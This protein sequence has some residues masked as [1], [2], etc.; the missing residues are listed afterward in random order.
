M[1]K[2]T[3][4][5]SQFEIDIQK[6][7]EGLRKVYS[8]ALEGK[9]LFYGGYPVWRRRF[10]PQWRIPQEL[11]FNPAREEVKSPEL[12]AKF[13][14]T[15]VQF[16]RQA[17]SAYLE[18]KLHQAWNSSEYRWF[19]SG[20]AVAEAK[21][22]DVDQVLD[23]VLHYNIRAR[24]NKTLAESVVHNARKL[25]DEYGGDPRNLIE[26]LTIT[27]AR[28]RHMAFE[29]IGTGI[30]N[31][32]LI[33]FIDRKLAMP[34]DPENILFKIDI[35]KGRIPLNLD[36]IKLHQDSQGLHSKAL[37]SKLEQ[38]YKQICKENNFNLS[39]ADAALWVIGSMGCSRSDEHCCY[40]IACPLLEGCV[41]NTPLNAY[42]GTFELYTSR[43]ER[44]N[45][46][47]HAGQSQLGLQYVSDE[48]NQIL[49]TLEERRAE[50]A[51]RNHQ[52]WRP[53]K[54]EVVRDNQQ[55]LFSKEV[56]PENHP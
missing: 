40:E 12:A 29:G 42:N 22:A 25:V 21:V 13:L 28:K 45:K 33:H 38:A 1:G 56:T 31:L 9:G 39:I 23:K 34:S 7:S 14:W 5:S 50:V 51:R 52:R 36:C 15:S 4:S 8:A 18:R 55:Y 24:P 30:A 6:L 20:E 43:G 2:V 27:E 17:N 32:N 10:L 44:K 48:V 49:T 54:Q 47:K 46:N 26:G 16:E 19:F 41:A 53:R 37:V 11:E 35:H 3:Y